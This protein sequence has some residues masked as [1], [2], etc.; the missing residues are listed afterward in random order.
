MGQIVKII[1][2]ISPNAFEKKEDFKYKIVLDN[3]ERK[4]FEKIIE[5]LF[6]LN[7]CVY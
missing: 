3:F 1:E 4:L 7:I 2:D 6:F 5:F